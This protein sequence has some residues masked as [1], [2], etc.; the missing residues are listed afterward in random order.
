MTGM[1]WRDSD[2][3]ET[4][5]EGVRFAGKSLDQ[6]LSAVA[7]RLCG[8]LRHDVEIAVVVRDR[9]GSRTWGSGSGAALSVVEPQSGGSDQAVTIALDEGRVWRSSDAVAVP[10]GMAERVIGAVVIR[11]A[12]SRRIDDAD[13][14]DAER[15][16]ADW[17]PTIDNAIAF[18]AAEARAKNLEIALRGR[19]V[20]EQAKGILMERERCGADQAFAVLRDRSQR[21]DLKLAAV[22]AQI[23]A[24]AQG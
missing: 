24:D 9:H 18:A 16:V 14:L 8:A 12:G 1:A 4:P 3:P 13:V 21:G 19:A 20:I 7:S 2:S 22:A 6:L 15:A 17:A 23:V 5:L 10:V 11:A